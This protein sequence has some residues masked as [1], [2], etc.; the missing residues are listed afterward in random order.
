M[1]KSG[2]ENPRNIVFTV[3]DR[4]LSI[5]KEYG[6][7]IHEFFDAAKGDSKKR[8][9]PFALGYKGIGMVGYLHLAEGIEVVSQDTN[10]TG[11]IYRFWIYR[12]TDENGKKA[13]YYDN[14]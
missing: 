8:R 12:G 13:R 10:H 14:L 3:Q 2:E 7:N 4:G 9:N 1:P 6:W 5:A 11:T